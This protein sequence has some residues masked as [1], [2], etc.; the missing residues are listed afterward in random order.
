[1]S[2]PKKDKIASEDLESRIVQQRKFSLAEA[3]G[4]KGG[5]LFKG[6][7][8]VPLE[9]RLQMTIEQWVQRNVPDG[10]GALRRV[11][12]RWVGENEPLMMAHADQP[13][14]AL[15]EVIEMILANEER[16]HEFVRQVD[17]EWGRMYQ[18][19]PHFERSGR[20]AD[21]DDPYT[22]ESVRAKLKT[23]LQAL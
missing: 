19:R 13:L 11:L 17:V 21:A 16:L 4:R 20:P 12:S 14:E 7:S 22:F 10:E 9:R 6:A 18:E 23:A 3:L 8:P 2:K 1:M 15:R 5:G